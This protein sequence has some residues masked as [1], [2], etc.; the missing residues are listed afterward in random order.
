MSPRRPQ[1]PRRLD[2]ALR[3]VTGPLAPRTPLAAV[4]GAWREAA[5]DGI[6][7]HARP[8]SERDGVVTV[9]CDAA[10]WAQELDLLRDDLVAGLRERLGDDAPT[11]FRFVVGEGRYSDPL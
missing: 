8:V 7:T 9:A 10:T 3:S 4:Q 6:A 5:G 11:R 1:R 2:A